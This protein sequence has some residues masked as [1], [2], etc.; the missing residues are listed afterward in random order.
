MYIIPPE[1]SHEVKVGCRVIIPFG[2]SN[3]KM[4]GLVFSIGTEANYTFIPKSIISVI[5]STPIITKPFFRLIDYLVNNTFCTYYDAIKTILP[6]GL[7][8]TVTEHFQVTDLISC[9]TLS[10]FSKIEQTTIEL[11]RSATTQKQI[12]AILDVHTKPSK[13]AVVSKLL[14]CGIIIPEKKVTNNVA[15]KTVK[16]LRLNEDQIDPVQKYTKQQQHVITFLSQMSFAM[17]KEVIYFCGIT[18]SVIKTMIRR[19]IL[20]C[21][22]EAVDTTYSTPQ[23][24]GQDLDTLANIKLSPE[25]NSAYDGILELINSPSANVALLHGI[26][27]S[28][29]TQVFIKLIEQVLEQGKQ[30]ILLVPEIA[31][32]PSMVDKFTRLFGEHIAVTHS[33]L[34]VTE[35][36]NQWDRIKKGGANIVIGTRSAIFTPLNNIGLI[37]M[38]EEG[39]GSYKSDNA[40]KYHARD[41]AKLRA[42]DNGATLLLASA[43][44]SLDSYYNALKGKYSL[45]TLNNRY[46]TSILPQVSIVDMKN[47]EK[48]Y[49]YSIFSR[50]LQFEINQNLEKSEQTILLLNRRGFNTYLSCLNCLKTIN[51]PHCDVALT[52][53]KSNGL[54]MCHYCGYSIQKIT[55]CP[56]CSSNAIKFMGQ[57]TQKLED[58]L[59]KLFT[60]ARVLRMDTDT[61]YSKYT[62]EKNFL[63]FKNGKYDIMIGTQMISKGLDFPN[64][65][66]VGVLDADKGLNSPDFSSSSRVFSL[67]TQAIGRSGRADKPGRAFIQ[68]FNP[69]N[70]I[71]KYAALQDYKGFFDYETEHRKIMVYPPFCDM[72]IATIS[73]EDEKLSISAADAF[74]DLLKEKLSTVK[75]IPIKI[76][77]PTQ[78]TVF[79]ANN[80]YRVRL[81]IKCKLNKTLRKLLKEC[82]L[83]CQTTKS[84]N[85][86]TITINVHND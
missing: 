79:K 25:Q 41:I 55:K 1:L 32:T 17:Q 9:I 77:G 28:G 31:L 50:T 54:L 67:I 39:E 11:L 59:N 20:T 51:C 13:K 72:V 44:P 45:F 19:G 29:K 37:I 86:V 66:L 46:S 76:L 71:I 36:L 47:E 35:R 56:S 4:A 14:E 75:N 16:M 34:S 53:H 42:Y 57:G 63:D 8:F 3:K 23:K 48:E 22:D 62:Y 49:N 10:D 52:Y 61:I 82:L 27:G 81:T 33:A 6:I 58:E 43:T 18:T 78:E 30:V 68:T 5:D 69:D 15:K 7:G 73:C 2:R 74:L 70:E 83:L 60:E 12:N 26:T 65:T 24:D 40:P 21:Y 84:L 64:V 85:R 38:D 80:K